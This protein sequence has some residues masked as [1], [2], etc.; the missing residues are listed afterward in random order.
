M[1]KL[2]VYKR[3]PGDDEF[4]KSLWG[5]NDI[6]HMVSEIREEDVERIAELLQDT[7]V[8]FMVFGKNTCDA[9]VT[10]VLLRSGAKLE[11]ITRT[12]AEDVARALSRQAFKHGAP[13][14]LHP[15]DFKAVN[16]QFQNPASTQALPGTRPIDTREIHTSPLYAEI[17]RLR[18]E[19]AEARDDLTAQHGRHASE[20]ADYMGTI[21]TLKAELAE[22]R[23]YKT[24][25]QQWQE[26]VANWL[27][28]LDNLTIANI[29]AQ[30][31][32]Q[33]GYDGLCYR[34][35]GSCSCSGDDLMFCGAPNPLCFARKDGEDE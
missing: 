1:G 14:V 28:P 22:A 19:L 16:E 33:H 25:V 21:A 32:E 15:E 18:A 7:N 3:Q 10:H 4:A 26:S 27:E 11:R 23:E 35:E 30:Y 31:M 2:F 29:V 13:G 20:C 6:G 5:R 12:K 34:E 17:D 9:A 24:Q 8:L